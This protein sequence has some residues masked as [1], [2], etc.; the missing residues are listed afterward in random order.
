VSKPDEPVPHEVVLAYAENT[1]QPAIV[2]KMARELLERRRGEYICPKCGL[3]Q[4]PVEDSD[5][6]IPW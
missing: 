6:G 3:R 2:R 4:T 1:M 5:G